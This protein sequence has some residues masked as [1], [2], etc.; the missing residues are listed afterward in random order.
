MINKLVIAGHT[1]KVKYINA[2]KDDDR[3]DLHGDFNSDTRCI[4]ICLDQ[5]PAEQAQTLFHEAIHAAMH[6]SGQAALLK[7]EHEE[8]IVVALENALWPVLP[9]LIKSHP[10]GK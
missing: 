8:G 6:L 9:Q 5:S 3:L 4:R 10:A 7:P 2:L 1:I